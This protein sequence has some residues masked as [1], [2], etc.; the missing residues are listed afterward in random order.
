MPKT[1]V[2]HTKLSELSKY[3]YMRKKLAK[4][5]ETLESLRSAA[6]SVTA[7]LT[8]MPS[9]PNVTDKVSA[10][11]ARIVDLEDAIKSLGKDMSLERQKLLS[12]IRS[13]DDAYIRAIYFL[14]FVECMTW[15]EVADA[16]GGGNSADSVRMTC[17]RHLG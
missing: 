4:Y 6:T 3:F 5:Q 16:V 15:T 12:Y 14:R 17:Y 2:S 7:D 9:N 10:F 11:A 13:I 1:E 8:G